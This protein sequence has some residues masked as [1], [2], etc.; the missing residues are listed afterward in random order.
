MSR[1]QKPRPEFFP[2]MP[3][4]SIEAFATAHGIE[5]L[6]WQAVAAAEIERGEGLVLIPGVTTIGHTTFK[7]IV[8]GCR[9]ALAAAPHAGNLTF[10]GATV[11]ETEA[12]PVGQITVSRRATHVF[13]H[14]LDIIALKHPRDPIARLDA[15]RAFFETRIN[16]E[17]DEL[18]AQSLACRMGRFE[19]PADGSEPFAGAY[20]VHPNCQ[21]R[22]EGLRPW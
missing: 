19:H 10:Y 14:P 20:H 4:G 16:R 17:F 2:R 8:E 7:N 6:P 18:D 22:R 11:I 1:S 21:R 12:V 5:L 15:V 9:A 13:L 3:P